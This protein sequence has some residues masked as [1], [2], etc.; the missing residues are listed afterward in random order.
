V[1]LPEWDVVS[2]KRAGPSEPRIMDQP[3]D[4]P[5]GIRA[6]NNTLVELIRTAYGPFKFP[7]A[8]WISGLP[9]WA[10]SQGFDIQAKVAPEDVTAFR[11]LN[12]EQRGLML[13]QLLS[14][15][16]KLKLHPS[17]DEHRIYELVTDRPK[18]K[19]AAAESPRPNGLKLTNGQ[20]VTTSVIKVVARGHVVAQAASMKSFAHFLS[21][22]F[23]GL[24]YPVVDKTGLTGTY[25]FSLQWSTN[26][27]SMSATSP[28]ESAPSLFSA[29]GEQ[30]GL[31]LRSAKEPVDILVIDHVE[32]PTEN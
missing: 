8:D 7:T 20:P 24:G 21:Q 3:I 12:P 25:D 22:P 13:Q 23:V 11:N 28:D 9:D 26:E 31:K 19:E 6:T 1:K 14:N 10:K 2:I 16:F 4:L 15:Y 17:T 5:D 18:L 32:E 29:I 30:L 27:M